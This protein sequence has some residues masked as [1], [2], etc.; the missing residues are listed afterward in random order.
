MAPREDVLYLRAPMVLLEFDIPEDVILECAYMWTSSDGDRELMEIGIAD[1]NGR[2]MA[3]GIILGLV[4]PDPPTE[5]KKLHAEIL[6]PKEH[7]ERV[8]RRHA[9]HFRKPRGH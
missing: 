9:R 6:V 2:L 3:E 4:R 8:L 7:A 5:D 1:E